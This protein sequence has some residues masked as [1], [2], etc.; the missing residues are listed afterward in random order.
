MPPNLPENPSPREIEHAIK[1]YERLIKK[2]EQTINE[3]KIQELILRDRV[4]M[5]TVHSKIDLN[6]VPVYTKYKNRGY[7]LIP[8]TDTEIDFFKE[9]SRQKRMKGKY[10]RY[11]QNQQHKNSRSFIDEKLDEMI[12]SHDQ[13]TIGFDTD[14]V[15]RIAPDLTQ[16]Q[17]SNRN[18]ST[19]EVKFPFSVSTPSTSKV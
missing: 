12:S 5:S 14:L 8:T 4:K 2:Q 18:S 15:Q 19:K 10:Y 6:L 1:S 16:D 17:D 3:T 11:L 9:E 7:H 13:E